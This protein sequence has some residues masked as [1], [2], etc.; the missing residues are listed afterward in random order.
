MKPKQ[1]VMLGSLKVGARFIRNEKEW[2]VKQQN[3][4][5][6]RKPSEGKAVC[7]QINTPV[8]INIS[9]DNYVV[10]V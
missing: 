1:P 9:R 2:E 8:I 4:S 3:W 5:K 10:P 6:E 7:W